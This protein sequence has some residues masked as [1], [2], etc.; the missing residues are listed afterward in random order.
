MCCHKM[1]DRLWA[2]EG[3]P[4]VFFSV[5][6]YGGLLSVSF[7]NDSSTRKYKQTNEALFFLVGL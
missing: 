2:N 3:Q 1:Y 4:Q 5:Y 6:I 7:A